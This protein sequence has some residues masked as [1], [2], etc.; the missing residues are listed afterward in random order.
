ML[1]VWVGDKKAGVLDRLPYGGSTFAYDPDATKGEEVSLTLPARVQSYDRQRGLTP[2]FDMNL[3]EGALREK[4]RL[5]FAKQLGTFDDFDLLGVVGRSQIGRIRFTGIDEDLVSDVPFQSV[6]EILQS[7]RDGSFV[8]HLIERYAAYS[9]VSGVQPKILLNGDETR[10]IKT[11]THIVKFSNEEYPELP[12]NEFF[13]LDAARRLGLDVPSVRLSEDADALVVDRF[14]VRDGISLGFEDFCVLNGLDTK[15]KYKG[16]YERSLFR[17]IRDF[18]SLDRRSASLRD[19]FTLFVLNAA[20]RN[21]DAHL[22]NWG[23]VYKSTNGP[24]GLAPVY[25]IVTTKAYLPNDQMALTLDARPTWP[26]AK[27]LVQLGTL[28][29]RLTA[30]AVNEILG[31]VADVL[32]EIAPDLKSHFDQTQHPEVGE[33]M[34]CAWNEGIS[35]SLGMTRDFTSGCSMG[36]I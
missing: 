22:K 23:V 18:V 6:D 28:R 24:V 27:Q 26:E 20:V 36:P 14:D 2:I 4:L 17:R 21:G 15:D 13:C 10:S 29:A 9:G 7:R 33:A 1:R 34:L 30:P 11:A 8:S 31:N 12:S 5:E 32:S 25:D 35:H 3:P 16:G 19:A